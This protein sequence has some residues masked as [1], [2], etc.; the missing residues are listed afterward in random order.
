[1]EI[2][3]AGDGT[4]HVSS[5][6]DGAVYAGI[7]GADCYVTSVG[8]RLSC[9]MQGAN[10]ALVGT[11]VGFMFGRAFRITIPEEVTIQ[12]GTQSQRRNDIIC[13]HFATSPD[14][15]ESGELVVL[16]GT[17]T[18]GAEAEDPEIPS[19]D[20]LEG[21]TEAYMPLWRIPLDGIN[22]GEPE[23]M[24]DVLLSMSELQGEIAEV[25]DSVS[26]NRWQTLLTNAAYYVRSGGL[27]VVQLYNLTLSKSARR[28]VG[29]LP[30]GFRPTGAATWDGR[31]AVG[32]VYGGGSNI[33]YAY[34]S[35]AGEVW[36]NYAPAD[37]VYTGQLVFPA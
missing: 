33:A 21:S 22:V 1:M 16:K 34:V 18:S 36:C 13:A 8:E 24:F 4:A 14:G 5:S 28:T 6:D 2:I 23:A 12:S 11:G 19:G 25:R 35:P 20:I 31:S 30:E 27:V 26:Q 37:G 32:F 15:H 29:T 3:T 9:T 10:T 17:P 7:V